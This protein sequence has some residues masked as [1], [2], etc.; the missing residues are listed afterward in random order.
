MW[1]SWDSYEEAVNAC[2]SGLGSPLD[3][4]WA[5]DPI[6]Y[7]NLDTSIAGQVYVLLI[8]NY[9]DSPNT[10]YFQKSG[11]AATTNCKILELCDG[12]PVTGD[13][14]N[15]TSCS[16]AAHN[17]VCDISCATGYEYTYL[18]YDPASCFEGDWIWNYDVNTACMD[19]DEC[20]Q[21]TDACHEWA[22]CFNN[23]GG[24]D[25]ECWAGYFGDGFSC[26]DIDECAEGTD[27]C[28]SYATCSNT[29]G[30]FTCSC[31]AGYEYSDSDNGFWNCADINECLDASACPSYSDCYNTDGAYECICWDGYEFD[32]SICVDIDECALGLDE[33]SSY[34]DC[35][36]TEGSYDCVCWAGYTGDG[37]DCAAPSASA[38]PP[39]PDPIC[40]EEVISEVNIQF[41]YIFRGL[42]TVPDCE[43]PN[44]LN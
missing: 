16:G 41:A 30:S 38:P 34:A 39:P 11:G 21:G 31:M 28:G 42:K 17:D 25:C 33:C 20:A 10:I 40:H 22:S 4:S 14:Y 2:D 12:E 15:P 32:G 23:P 35:M 27:N 3:C 29:V 26:S 13:A 7:A 9:D 24:Y 43:D 18:S 5:A 37:Y 8:T 6:E 44:L 36:N 19:I 1:G